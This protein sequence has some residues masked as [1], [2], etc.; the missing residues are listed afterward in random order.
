MYLQ[1]EE[2]VNRDI[3]RICDHILEM[4]RCAEASLRDCIKAFL[5]TNH[6]LAYAIILR[7][8]Y[9][10]EKEKEIDR[11][12]LEFIIKQQPV[13][14]PL[15]FAFSAIKLNVV[16]IHRGSARV[17]TVAIR[18]ASWRFTALVHQRTARVLQQRPVRG[19]L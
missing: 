15:R 2:S 4:A 18:W 14:Q 6:E 1:H 12:C 13:A 9:I 3:K 16:S 19:L 8:Q 5:E 17:L 7:D 11:L 10:D